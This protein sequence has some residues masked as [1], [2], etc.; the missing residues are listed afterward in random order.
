MKSCPGRSFSTPKE[1]EVEV[2]NG[3]VFVDVP[4][5]G[6]KALSYFIQAAEKIGLLKAT[7][8]LVDRMVKAEE[9]EDDP[10]CSTDQLKCYRCGRT[11]LPTAVVIDHPD[12]HDGRYCDPCFTRLRGGD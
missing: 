5:S 8:L 1:C 7:K 9:R 6:E 12:V 3:V 10:F 4:D 2:K 11:D